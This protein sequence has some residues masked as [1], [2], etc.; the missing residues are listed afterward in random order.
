[1][2]KITKLIFG[3]FL[4]TTFGAILG[5]HTVSADENTA[6]AQIESRGVDVGGIYHNRMGSI[7]SPANTRNV[8]DW[9]MSNINDVIMFNNTNSRNQKWILI[10]NNV[11]R[12]YQIMGGPLSA[13]GPGG[14]F[15][16][17][18][19]SAASTGSGFKVD[20][21]WN[22]SSDKWRMYRVN[23]HANGNIVYIQNVSTSLVM[24]TPNGQN[25]RALIL[26]PLNGRDGSANQRYIVH[27]EGTV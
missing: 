25:N 9:S 21:R 23:T 12:T 26:S 13:G 17:A 24:E 19:L 7:Q 11:D 14:I 20:T 5:S 2:K 22:I 10:Y 6:K 3:I 8:I 15:R 27:V 1:M 18:Y 16:A 4:A